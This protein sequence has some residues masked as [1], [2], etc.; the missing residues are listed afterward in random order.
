M[1]IIINSTVI[2]III[3]DDSS[4]TASKEK[5]LLATL[6][7]VQHHSWRQAGNKGSWN[8]KIEICGGSSH[9]V[10]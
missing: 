6:A 9:G 3:K 8:D 4:L 1:C 10:E 2:I 5:N 7:D